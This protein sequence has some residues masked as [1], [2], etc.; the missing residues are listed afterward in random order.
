MTNTILLRAFH[1]SHCSQRVYCGELPADVTL[2]HTSAL[3]LLVPSSLR[4]HREPLVLEQ[5]SR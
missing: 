5:V 2:V 3:A 4:A 1:S